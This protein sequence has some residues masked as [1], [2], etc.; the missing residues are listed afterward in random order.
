MTSGQRAEFQTVHDLLLQMVQ[1]EQEREKVLGGLVGEIKHIAASVAELRA[2][3]QRNGLMDEINELK[4]QIAK[5]GQRLN[6][7]EHQ[8]QHIEEKLYRS[9]QTK[10]LE[11]IRSFASGTERSQTQ[12][13]KIARISLV[14]STL[15]ALL[16]I[17]L[18]KL[19]GWW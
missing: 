4:L 14:I 12:A 2:L 16:G 8:R 10:L 11:D 19:V 6:D 7:E 18:S 9:L 5:I 13:N 3:I 15:L 17:F 1:R